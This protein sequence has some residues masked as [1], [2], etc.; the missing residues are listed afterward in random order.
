MTP[1]DVVVVP[2]AP[3]LLPEYAGLADPV[4]E[5][6]TACHQA[7]SWLVRRHPDSVG[8]AAA[9]P[10]ADN[11]AR[12]VT[13]AAGHRIARH[14]LAAAGFEGTLDADAD[15]GADGLLV[16]ANGSA[17]RGVKAPGHLHPGSAAFDKEVGRALAEGDPAAL[18]RLDGAAAEE[19][20]CFDVPALQ[21]LG[22]RATTPVQASIDYADDPYGVQ[23]WVVRWTC[24]S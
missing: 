20:W 18:M 8:V 10:R 16:V 9:G 14:L 19:L 2:S 24:G 4:P 15:P 22:R 7:V 3:A 12:G 11:R 6:R 23:Y 17:T 5:L 13:E 21:T 1:L